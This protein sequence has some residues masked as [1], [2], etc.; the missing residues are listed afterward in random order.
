MS[1]STVNSEDELNLRLSMINNKVTQVSQLDYEIDLIKKD[2]LDIYHHR[3]NIEISELVDIHSAW[4]EQPKK[5][6]H[7][8]YKR[9]YLK[10]TYQWFMYWIQTKIFEN[11]LYDVK[12]DDMLVIIG[13]GRAAIRVPF[14]YKGVDFMI[15]IPNISVINSFNDMLSYGFYTLSRRESETHTVTFAKFYSC[16]E[17]KE[18]IKETLDKEIK[19]A[20]KERRIDLDKVC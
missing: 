13:W 1:V 16:E 4:L 8:I 20:S 15:S 19:D 12:F 17:V 11:V 2:C 7:K 18:K 14:K 5:I 6:T 9:Q 10:T 3:N